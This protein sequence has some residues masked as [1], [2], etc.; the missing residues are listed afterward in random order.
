MLEK[1]KNR[2]GV[3]GIQLTLILLTFALGGSCCG[4]LGRRILGLMPI[5]NT[6]LYTIIYIITITL[7]WPVCVILISIP[8]GQFSFFRNYLRKIFARLTGTK[9]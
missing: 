8:L 3:N 2:W 6:F 1:L 9:R 5:D 7:L 4:A